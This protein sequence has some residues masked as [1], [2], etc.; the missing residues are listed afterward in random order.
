MFYNEE[1]KTEFINDYMRSRVV[2]KTTLTGLFNK[3]EKF[4]KELN[5][6]CSEF[7]VDE[8]MNMY[9]SFDSK[10]VN[11]LLN[12]NV[13]LKNYTSYRIYNKQINCSNSYENINKDMMLLC[14]NEATR[15]AQFLTREQM[16]DIEDQ[17]FNFTDKAI[18]ECLWHGIAGKDLED[19]VSINRSM[20]SSEDMSVTLN[21]GK[22][23]YITPR[24]YDY[25]EEAFNETDYMCYGETLRIKEV[26]GI[27]RLYKER[28]NAHTADSKDKYFRWV[29]RK[30]QTFRNY[31]DLPM[32]TMKNIQASGLLYGIQSG[33]N[34][35]GL[36]MRKFLQTDDGKLIA[37]QYGYTLDYYVDTI[38][39]KFCD[40]IK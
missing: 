38:T 1:V 30:I 37:T 4:E 40:I 33:M 12:N 28:D 10:S 39:G 2:A 36:D 11:V 21:S 17:L 16:N 20:V 9:K 31:V 27:G 3:T 18:V 26:K 7:T 23:M 32:L 35:T 22:K 25:L 19:L 15:N 14:I 34:R 5:K 24:L 29:Y 8:I 13:Y 6:D